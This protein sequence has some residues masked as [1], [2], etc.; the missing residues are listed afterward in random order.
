ME[1]AELNQIISLLKQITRNQESMSESLE[2]LLNL[3]KKY[4]IEEVMH[5]ENLRDG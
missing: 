2:N 1:N 3:F 4:E 5:S